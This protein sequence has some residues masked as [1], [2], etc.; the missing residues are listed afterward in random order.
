MFEFGAIMLVPFPFT[1]LSSS[2]LRPALIVSAD[3]P[4]NDDVIVCFITSQKPR[5]G[6]FAPISA[7]G[8]TGLKLS[9]YVRF[10]KIA[11]LNKR[12]FAGRLGRVE[13]DF[14]KDNASKFFDVFGVKPPAYS[15]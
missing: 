2:K 10:E 6:Q 12:I 8:E 15:K 7:T 5:G 3:N 11:T 9:S 4:K 13:A 1:D 14:W